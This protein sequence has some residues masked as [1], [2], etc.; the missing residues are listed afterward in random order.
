MC[1]GEISRSPT[2]TSRILLATKMR[3]PLR[4]WTDK[5]RMRDGGWYGM[6]ALQRRGAQ[7]RRGRA[8]DGGFERTSVRMSWVVLTA[9][10]WLCTFTCNSGGTLGRDA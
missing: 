3:S 5:V 2:D 10:S 6:A 8:G 1:E 7:G 4:T 9:A